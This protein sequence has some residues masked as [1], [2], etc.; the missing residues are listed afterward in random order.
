MVK[1]ISKKLIMNLLAILL[2]LISVIALTACGGDDTSKVM[3]LSLNPEIELI[4]DKNNKVVTVNALNDEGNYIVANVDFSGLSAE[5]AVDRF[6]Q[7]VKDNGFLIEDNVSVSEN[8]LEISISGENAQKLIDQVKASAQDYLTNLGITATIETDL[9]DKDYLEGLVE[10]CMQEMTDS[11]IEAL[12]EEELI[13]LLKTSRNETKNL[14]SEELKELYYQ[15]RADEI[16]ESKYEAV[17]NMLDNTNSQFAEVFTT[18]TE[19]YNNLTTTITNLRTTYIE[20]FLATGSEYQEK[21]QNY[22]SAKQALLEARLDEGITNY[23]QLELA[24]QIAESALT[25]AENSANLAMEVFETSFN[26]YK[27]IL[28]TNLNLIASFL[29]QDTINQAM[30]TTKTNFNTQF[31]TTYQTYINNTNWNG[32]NPNA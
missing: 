18:M 27:T 6:L 24:V 31:T 1:Q 14:L 26:T 2:C 12:S 22:I 21:V 17:M 4:L 30:E 9:L 23:T 29:N 19:A 7:A 13:N 11:E 3:N 15:S 32:L 20:R 16:I 28:N 10:E 5:D 25:V 8:E